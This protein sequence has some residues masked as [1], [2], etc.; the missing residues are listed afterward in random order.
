MYDSNENALKFLEH[1]K[2]I[3]KS[4]LLW[5]VL[6]E[7]DKKKAIFGKRNLTV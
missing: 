5:R 3:L 7:N 4:K 2:Q 6:E 1:A